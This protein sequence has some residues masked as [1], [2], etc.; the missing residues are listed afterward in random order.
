MI[1]YTVFLFRITKL[2]LGVLSKKTKRNEKSA[3]KDA[4]QRHDLRTTHQVLNATG[5]CETIPWHRNQN[6]VNL[7]D[8]DFLLT[9][10]QHKIITN[11]PARALSPTL[12]C[13]LNH[14]TESQELNVS[15]LAQLT[16]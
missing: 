12:S 4:L 2:A 11:S 5:R 7:N 15:R 13:S 6:D 3:L 10:S 16:A 1:D 8:K 9:R 14:I